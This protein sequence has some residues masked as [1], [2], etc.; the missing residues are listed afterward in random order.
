MVMDLLNTILKD[1][2]KHIQIEDLHAD[3][4]AS[5]L[6][7]FGDG[8]SIQIELDPAEEYICVG[9]KLGE[10]PSG[11]Y[12]QSLFKEALKANG[13]P[14]PRIGTFAYSEKSK[15]LIYF[16]YLWAKEMTG[17]RLFEFVQQFKSKAVLWKGAIAR[18]EIPQ[19]DLMAPKGARPKGMFGL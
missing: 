2:E 17:Q 14:P 5:C 7:N 13:L 9:T 11:R 15:S 16:E 10:V 6:I 12:R 19:L 3:E 4:N 18:G 1:L 8:V